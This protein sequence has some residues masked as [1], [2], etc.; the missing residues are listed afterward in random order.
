MKNYTKH[1]A[2]LSLSLLFL[3]IAYF[4]SFAQTKIS[5][6]FTAVEKDA[7][8]IDD[9]QKEIFD[10]SETDENTVYQSLV[11]IGEV[12]KFLEN[13]VVSFKFP[14]ISDVLTATTNYTTKSEQEG[15]V[16][17]GTL[18]DDK[19]DIT[20]ISK[21]GAK[22]GGIT[23][24]DHYYSFDDI[25]K[26][27]VLV[28]EVVTPEGGHAL[29][30]GIKDP[31]EP[32]SPSEYFCEL[33]PNV[34]EID[35]LYLFTPNA[36]SATAMKNK[37][38]QTTTEMNLICSNS[39]A[40]VHF[41]TVATLSMPIPNFDKPIDPKGYEPG[42]VSKMATWA[43]NTQSVKDLRQ[44]NGADIV[45]V[46]YKGPTKYTGG[47]GTVF[48][49]FAG[50]D[51]A[52]AYILAHTDFVVSKKYQIAMLGAAEILGAGSEA[53]SG[54]YTDSRPHKY[55]SRFTVVHEGV[56]V[57]KSRYISN[58]NVQDGGADTGVANSRD[59]VRAMNKKA[60]EVSN[61]YYPKG[62]DYS[63]GM[64]ITG[65]KCIDHFWIQIFPL[66]EVEADVK[67]YCV[68][69]S[70]DG[71]NFTAPD[72]NS[73]PK[74][75]IFNPSSSSK[76]YIKCTIKLKNGTINSTTHTVDLKGCI[77]D[78]IPTLNRQAR[79]NIDVKAI[80]ITPNPAK[81]DFSALVTGFQ[82][83]NV[84]MNILDSKSSNVVFSIDKNVTSNEY[85]QDFNTSNL[86]DGIYFL[87]LI[88]DETIITK[89]IVI[90]HD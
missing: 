44:A 69:I 70:T 4:N 18:A 75:L 32:Q 5:P 77:D 83:Q 20:I 43:S 9:A 71:I 19:G 89:K 80:F 60:C 41:N 34:K 28:R 39:Q 16:W 24:D 51:K 30:A 49:S 48:G 17:N 21:D 52:G 47:V 40:L 66:P 36:G 50:T 42:E 23:Y 1:L 33:D 45:I 14:N 67:E 82:D 65:S 29:D 74:F 90:A 10:K 38:N 27:T 68:E 13:G 61:Y 11:Q 72:C 76:L 62:V 26:G 25:G 87:Q 22:Y 54:L 73:Y 53:R 3:T 57:N 31:L 58:P 2:K 37:A 79:T 88:S 35:V 7:P 84:K 59:N 55:G 56:P 12:E 63:V 85:Y 78:P 64:Q 8:S 6:L 86:L 15:F 46:L 81:D